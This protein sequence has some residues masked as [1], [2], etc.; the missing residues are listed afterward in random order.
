MYNPSFRSSLHPGVLS[1]RNVIQCPLEVS[2][3]IIKTGA[4]LV[5]VEIRVNELNQT[6]QIFGR[7]LHNLVSFQ[8]VTTRLR[9]THS[10]ILLIEI[11]HIAI[12][13]LDKQLNRHC[14]IHTRICDAQ[15]TL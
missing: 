8:H 15:R 13:N 11:V 7:H 6:V 4:V 9:V 10:L 2:S 12:E 1:T 14:C 5:C 3:R